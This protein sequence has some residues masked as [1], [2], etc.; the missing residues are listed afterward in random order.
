VHSDASIIHHGPQSN[1]SY[2]N[3]VSDL[4]YLLFS[5]NQIQIPVVYKHHC[6]R[7][8]LMDIN[9]IINSFGN[10]ITDAPRMKYLYNKILKELNGLTIHQQNQRKRNYVFL[11]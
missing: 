10:K 7:I 6:P 1:N 3:P 8:N 2:T 11:T 9:V 5:S 4:G